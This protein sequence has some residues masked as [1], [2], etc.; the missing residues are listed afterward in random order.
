MN[1]IFMLLRY[2]GRF[3]AEVIF[4]TLPVSSERIGMIHV[5]L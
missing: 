3:I 2:Q 4:I 1:N 5:Q